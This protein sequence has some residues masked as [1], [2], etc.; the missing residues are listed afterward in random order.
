MVNTKCRSCDNCHSSCWNCPTSTSTDNCKVNESR[1]RKINKQVRMDASLGLLKKKS[2]LVSQQ[3]GQSADPEHL[4]QAGGPGDLQKS[5]QKSNIPSAVRKAAC[6]NMGIIRNRT[7]YNNKSGV[8]KKHGS[9]NRYL[10]RKV[11]GVLRT[12]KMPHVRNRLA[13]IG[14]P[15]VRTLTTCSCDKKQTNPK[16]STT[17]RQNDLKCC[18]NRIPNCNQQTLFTGKHGMKRTCV[19]GGRCRCCRK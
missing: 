13:F 18:K 2:L 1:L 11:G 15:R 6:Y 10:A 5:I 17:Q 14:Q 4:L 7:S 9:Y 12:E 3:V 16:C 19:A 8:D